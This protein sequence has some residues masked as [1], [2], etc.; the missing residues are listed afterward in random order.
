MQKAMHQEDLPRIPVLDV[1]A[2]FPKETLEREEARAHRLLDAAT[3]FVPKTALKSLDSVSRRWLARCDPHLLDEIDVIAR[4]L[5]RPGA[6]FLSV[7]YEWGCTVRVAPSPDGAPGARL[8]RVLDWR[9]HGLGRYIVAARVTA[10]AGRFVTMT[11]PGYTGVLQ[12]VAPGRFA[13]ALNQAPMR[14]PTGIYPLDWSANRWRVWRRAQVTPAHLL[15]QAFERAASYQ[16]AREMLTET[17]IAAPCIYAIAGLEAD[18]TCIIERTEETAY[19]HEG[20]ASAANHWQAPGWAGR[21]RGIDSPGRAMRM[22]TAQ[23]RLDGTFPWLD[24]P[25]L[26]AHTR[27]AMVADARGGR[28]VAQGYEHDGPATAVLELAA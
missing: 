25:I 2:G 28:L 20:R 16:E 26:N 12:A 13:A 4:R 14:A 23:A 15:R 5:A 8:I 3:R 22:T 18:E 10:P 17:P 27:L 24:H 9:T 19:V 21:N 7:N 1:G 11:W 6:Y